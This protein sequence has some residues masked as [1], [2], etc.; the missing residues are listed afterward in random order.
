LAEEDAADDEAE[1]DELPK[2][3]LDRLYRYPLMPTQMMRKT[4]A[5]R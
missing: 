2:P 3:P 4:V 5:A 1:D